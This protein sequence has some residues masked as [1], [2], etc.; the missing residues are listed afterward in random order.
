[1]AP[2]THPKRIPCLETL[3]W[4]SLA[5]CERDRDESC[6]L[7]CGERRCWNLSSQLLLYCD[8][9]HSNFPYLTESDASLISTAPLQTLT[10]LM[11][12]WDL[13]FVI[14]T[15]SDCN[16]NRTAYECWLSWGDLLSNWSKRWACMCAYEGMWETTECFCVTQKWKKWEKKAFDLEGD[17]KIRF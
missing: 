8:I 14:C 4:D 1:M 11:Y 13:C 15:L 16:R 10:S 3:R 7:T 12:R 2:S 6:F 17:R 9:L 5:L